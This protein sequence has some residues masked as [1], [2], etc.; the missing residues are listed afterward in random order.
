[1]RVCVYTHTKR[2]VQTAQ[3]LA[4][5]LQS[6]VYPAYNITDKLAVRT[7]TAKNIQE[8]RQNKKIAGVTYPHFKVSTKLIHT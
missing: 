8:Y 7:V 2:R 6:T 1:M 3:Y 4:V 5:N